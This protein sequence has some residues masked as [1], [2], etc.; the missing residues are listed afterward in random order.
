MIV[1]EIIWWVSA[2]TLVAFIV[3]SC[4]GVFLMDRYDWVRR[5]MYELYMP[6]C[7]WNSK[8]RKERTGE[9]K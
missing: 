6:E 5:V 9:A 2:G 1:V 4:I 3:L 8:K 7:Y